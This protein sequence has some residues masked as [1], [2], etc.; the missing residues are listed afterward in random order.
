MLIVDVIGGFTQHEGRVSGSFILSEKIRERL[1]Q[2]NSLSARVA[3]LPWNLDWEKIAANRYLIRQLYPNEEIVHVVAAYSY[4]VGHGL[5]QYAKNLDRYGMSIERAVLCDG[6]HRSRCFKWRSLFGGWEIL[7][8]ENIRSYHGFFQ[9]KTRP[10]G[11]KPIGSECLSWTEI[12]LPHVEMDDAPE[13]HKR[14]ISIVNDLLLQKAIKSLTYKP[15]K[16]SK[17]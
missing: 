16:A 1:S 7:L 9:R 11:C 4:G 14:T 8:P 17:S 13:W 5:V 6:I 3:F 10:M 2:Y 12:A 15:R